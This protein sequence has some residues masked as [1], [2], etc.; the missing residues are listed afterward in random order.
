LW[1]LE[2]AARHPLSLRER[3]RVRGQRVEALGVTF[4][5]ANA[6]APKGGLL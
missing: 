2:T 1:S 4:D 6:I 5:S 3:V